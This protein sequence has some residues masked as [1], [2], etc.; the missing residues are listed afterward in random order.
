M[1]SVPPILFFLFC[2][3]PKQ[4]KADHA[5][6]YRDAL[7]YL[8]CVDIADIPGKC[9]ACMLLYIFGCIIPNKLKGTSIVEHTIQKIKKL[10]MESKDPHMALLMFRSEHILVQY[11]HSLRCM[12]DTILFYLTMKPPTLNCTL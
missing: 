12:L 9:T 4:L 1:S 11:M 2:F 10:L 8:G 3:F 6:Y 5:A 7:R